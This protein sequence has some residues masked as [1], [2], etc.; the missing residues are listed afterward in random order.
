[1]EKE[2]LG[3]VKT[4]HVV[5]AL[6]VGTLAWGVWRAYR[7]R[8]TPTTTTTTTPNPKPPPPPPAPGLPGVP[9][10][11]TDALARIIDAPGHRLQGPL[12]EAGFEPDQLE[13]IVDR[14]LIRLASASP[15]SSLTWTTISSGSCNKDAE[16]NREYTLKCMIYDKESNCAIE[17][18]ARVLSLFKEDILKISELRPSTTHVP[19]PLQVQDHVPYA[20]Y[21]RPLQSI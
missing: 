10:K 20:P 7:H 2:H 17:V 1:M 4:S 21:E 6:A 3:N 14:V 19:A 12:A 9:K 16:G 13:D 15:S 5:V 11:L 8:Y 18:F